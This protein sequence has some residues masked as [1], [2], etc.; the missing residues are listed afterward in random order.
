MEWETAQRME[1]SVH[2]Y[3]KKESLDCAYGKFTSRFTP[4]I[5]VP[6]TVLLL[7]AVVI[8]PRYFRVQI[9]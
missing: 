6:G 5:G 4:E 3:K 8:L 9:H 2:Y 7:L 1:E